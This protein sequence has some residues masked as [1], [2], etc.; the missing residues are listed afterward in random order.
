MLA[1]FKAG[2]ASNAKVV[3]RLCEHVQLMEM[4]FIDTRR[5]ADMLE[6][7]VEASREAS[8]ALP[9]TT[10]SQSTDDLLLF[11]GVDAKQLAMIAARTEVFKSLKEKGYSP[12]WHGNTGIRYVKDGVTI[13][14]SF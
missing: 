5:K 13:D 1:R 11:K 12:K 6:E 3:A 14:Y 10:T 9:T 2:R 4:A 7:A 8:K